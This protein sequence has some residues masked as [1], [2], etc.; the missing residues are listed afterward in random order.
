[1]ETI[2]FKLIIGLCFLWCITGY[3]QKSTKSAIDFETSASWIS[4][5][6]SKIDISADGKFMCYSYG[7]NYLLQSLDKKKRMDFVNVKSTEFTAD[8]KNLIFKANKDTLGFLQLS[9]FKL[10]YLLGV[11]KY[12]LINTSA[13]QRLCYE[14]KDAKG[15]LFIR[16]VEKQN[17][18][19]YDNVKEFYADNGDIVVLKKEE[20]SNAGEVVSLWVGSTTKPNELKVW[21]RN[22][23]EISKLALSKGGNRLLFIS[24]YKADHKSTVWYWST[25]STEPSVVIT[26]DH[27]EIQ[28]EQFNMAI[29]GAKFCNHD[30]S[31]L[32]DINEKL[33]QQA[34]APVKL[35]I[36]HQMES[37]LPDAQN[38]RNYKAVVNLKNRKFT[39]LFKYK[40][41]ALGDDDEGKWIVFYD[42]QSSDQIDALKIP[43]AQLVDA[44]T[45]LTKRLS[46]LTKKNWSNQ[47]TLLSKDLKYIVYFDTTDNNWYSYKTDKA[48]KNNLTKGLSVNWI[49]TYGNQAFTTAFPVLH[50][51]RGDQ[52]ILLTDGFDIWLF[53]ILNRVKPINITNGFGKKNN[54][55]FSI[56]TD[57][58][59]D[60]KKLATTDKS[61]VVYGFNETNKKSGFYRVG[62]TGKADPETL[63]L[64]DFVTINT[65]RHMASMPAFRGSMP[66]K[67]KNVDVYIVKRSE[68]GGSVNIFTTS[69]FRIFTSLSNHYPEK[70][71]NW[72]TSELHSWK[73]YKGK[74][75]QGILFKPDNFD[76][77]KKYPV[78]FTYYEKYANVLNSFHWTIPNGAKL[79]IPVLVSQEYLVFTPDIQ[80]E[81]GDPGESTYDCVASAADYLSK[82]PFVDSS[83]FGL[84]GQS[85]GGYE[86]NAIIAKTSKFAAAFSGAGPT[87]LVSL[88]GGL[89]LGS[90]PQQGFVVQG[91]LRMGKK[92]WEDPQA[93]IRNSPIFYSDKINTPLLMMDNRN[94]QLVN[95]LQGIELFT[96]LRSLNKPVWL[97]EY[98]N[99]GHSSGF[100]N[101]SMK[102][103][104][105][106]ILQ[107][108][109]HYLKNKPA[110]NWM[111]REFLKRYR[112]RDYQ[113]GFDLD[114]TKQP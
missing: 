50:W 43:Q 111:T 60:G 26:D 31:L 29:S 74:T 30:G 14:K 75:V 95:F 53:D 54:I 98:D 17:E 12:K 96:A 88:F 27:P 105:T 108:F 91:Q 1:M 84:M 5:E 59:S 63:S 72:Y 104:N 11:V 70:E 93:Y 101:P 48:Q 87:N 37:K 90:H 47:E 35:N 52:K 51:L 32:I 38:E 73:S 23:S 110:P 45:G 82:L 36:W 8:S 94:D 89:W 106:R 18:F 107:F 86:T 112:D 114:K 68:K 4:L 57:L 25:D 6:R 78:V 109:D 40:Q 15:K 19:S 3:A 99:G 100:D 80:Y 79:P 13:G 58:D 92:L 61:F 16:D 77:A 76:P 62:F 39:W 33:V 67:A 102:D 21:Q 113:S 42:D 22:D 24:R 46:G 9:T 64:G 34:P 83:K 49:N 20:Q 55:I 56:G 71:F 85:M 7:K 97:L 103:L 69:D 2:G 28:K 41:N 65:G 81:I 10:S 66:I 44:E